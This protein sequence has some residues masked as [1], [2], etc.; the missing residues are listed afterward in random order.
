MLI[1]LTLVSDNDIHYLPYL[2]KTL[3]YL[4]GTPKWVL[5]YTGKDI[6]LMPNLQNAQVFCVEFTDF[7]TTKNTLM[8]KAIEIYPTA[9][10]FWWFDADEVLQ[11][12]G[13][14]ILDLDLD[15]IS[16]RVGGI[17][18]NIISPSKTLVTEVQPIWSYLTR[19][20]RTKYRY[21]NLVHENI[22]IELNADDKIII[23]PFDDKLFVGHFG[24][25]ISNE[26]ILQKIERNDK[27]LLQQIKDN[28]DN[29]MCWMYYARH[30]TI[31]GQYG[32]AAMRYKRALACPVVEPAVRADWENFSKA[33]IIKGA[34][35]V[36]QAQNNLGYHQV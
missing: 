35:N 2:E 19:I 23:K 22:N 36:K 29:S 30:A 31:Q 7:S 18:I 1:I 3:A 6:N 28:P 13:E 10:W 15:S 27:F 21:R 26:Q 25:D 17:A 12:W 14:P 34:E 8:D 20:F 11:T 4:P 9:E 32:L 33:H 24:Y 5:G 16:D